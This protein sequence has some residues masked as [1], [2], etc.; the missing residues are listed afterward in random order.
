VLINQLGI[1]QK[2]A[3]RVSRTKIE[4]RTKITSIVSS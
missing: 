2:V 1:N 4:V 3:A